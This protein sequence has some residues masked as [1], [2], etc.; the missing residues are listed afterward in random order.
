MLQPKKTS[1]THHR[2]IQD[3]KKQ[4]VRWKTSAWYMSRLPARMLAEAFFLEAKLSGA[5]EEDCWRAGAV[6][7]QQNLSGGQ[8]RSIYIY[9]YN[10]TKIQHVR[11][12][13]NLWNDDLMIYRTGWSCCPAGTC[14]PCVFVVPEASSSP[15][16][17][18]PSLCLHQ[19]LRWVCVVAVAISDTNRSCA[20]I[21]DHGHQSCVWY[22][23]AALLGQFGADHGHIISLGCPLNAKRIPPN[24]ANELGIHRVVRDKSIKESKPSSVNSLK[25][26]KDQ[27]IQ[28]WIWLSSKNLCRPLQYAS[29][30]IKL[31][32]F[33]C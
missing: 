29:M 5:S 20:M 18:T 13:D 4:R 9:I 12:L 3:R 23:H 25:R 14:S 21:W 8:R 19:E 1:G 11:T 27:H 24:I 15:P 31:H 32:S 10:G 17:Y 26:S 6:Y 33:A 28:R 7:P 30:L 2:T 16:W 22:L